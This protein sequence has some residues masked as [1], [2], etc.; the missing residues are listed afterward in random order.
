[1][2]S[3]SDLKM[4]SLHKKQKK[5]RERSRSPPCRISPERLS[6]ALREQPG[7]ID[8]IRLSGR[9][10]PAEH[11]LLLEAAAS[12][13]ENRLELI[14]PLS[15]EDGTMFELCDVSDAVEQALKSGRIV[16]TNVNVIFGKAGSRQ[17]K[18]ETVLGATFRKTR[19]TF[20]VSEGPMERMLDF[21]QFIRSSGQGLGQI[22]IAFKDRETGIL[23]RNLFRIIGNSHRKKF[24]TATCCD[25]YDIEWAES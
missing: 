22:V 24:G 1:M 21:T 12:Q 7:I 14:F 11:A 17:L 9:D 23:V 2:T 20:V 15:Y 3:H 8:L 16:A 6:L 5:E 4:S 18:L 10:R 25:V 13:P 19:A